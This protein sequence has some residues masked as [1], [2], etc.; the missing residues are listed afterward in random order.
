[1]VDVSDTE[2]SS[3]VVL[4][5]FTR[6]QSRLNPVPESLNSPDIA[7]GKIKHSL[8]RIIFLVVLLF[9]HIQVRPRLAEM[10]P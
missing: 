2:M 7:P 9:Y 1:M 8:M 3:S 10:I 4:P 5:G 6:I